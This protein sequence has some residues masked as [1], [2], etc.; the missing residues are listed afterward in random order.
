[1]GLRVVGC[2]LR[3]AG[4]RVTGLEFCVVRFALRYFNVKAIRRKRC[5]SL[6]GGLATWRFGACLVNRRSLEVDEI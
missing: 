5:V 3:V 6:L 1:M 4:W 2:E